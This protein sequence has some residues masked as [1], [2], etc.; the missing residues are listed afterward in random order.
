MTLESESASPPVQHA[1]KQRLLRTMTIGVPYAT[2]ELAEEIDAPRRSVNRWLHDLADKGY[3][4]K[5]QPNQTTV[6]WY[7]PSN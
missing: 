2:S 5:K 7:R 6:M 4:T 3:V 1:T